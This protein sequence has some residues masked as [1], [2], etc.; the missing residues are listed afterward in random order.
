MNEPVLIVRPDDD[1]LGSKHVA[2]YALLMVIIDV[3]DENINT[4]FKHGKISGQINFNFLDF[5][6]NRDLGKTT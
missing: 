3:L 5:Y 2:L 4:L 6:Y 1:S